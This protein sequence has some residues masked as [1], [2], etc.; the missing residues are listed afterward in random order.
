VLHQGELALARNF[1]AGRPAMIGT[2]PETGRP[3]DELP[4]FREALARL[5]AAEA[6]VGEIVPRGLIPRY[7]EGDFRLAAD[8]AAAGRGVKVFVPWGLYACVAE[9]HFRPRHDD[10]CVVTD[11]HWYLT[12]GYV[13]RAKYAGLPRHDLRGVGIGRDDFVVGPLEDW[14]PSALRLDGATQ[15]LVLPDANLYR[16]TNA[17]RTAWQKPGPRLTFDRSQWRTPDVGTRSFLIEAYLRPAPGRGGMILAKEDGRTGYALDLNE[18]GCPRLRLQSAG[19]LVA[20]RVAATTVADDAWHHLVVEI[21]RARSDGITFWIDGRTDAGPLQGRV[22]AAELDNAGD[23]LV[24]GGP[25][26]SFF[27]GE[28][29][30]LRLCLGTLA[31]ART[32]IDELRAWEFAGPQFAN[33]I[34]RVPAGQRDAGALQHEASP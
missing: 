26:R 31:D 14:A 23:V 9:W 15:Y 16:P 18:H 11:H 5:K 2:L 21:D 19:R 7:R 34:G 13:D 12:W 4:A 20:E 3:V 8:S 27:R 6:S 10:P 1:L 28:L 25:G 24:G 22:T 29:A 32:T 17:E 33:F 30:F